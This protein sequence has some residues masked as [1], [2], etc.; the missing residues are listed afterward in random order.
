MGGAQTTD[1]HAETLDNAVI[2]S[3]NP[4]GTADRIDP[5]M[6]PWS[7]NR[8]SILGGGMIFASK[9]RTV[10]SSVNIRIGLDDPIK[11][12]PSW[13]IELGG[14][15]PHDVSGDW[16]SLQQVI[17]GNTFTVWLASIAEA[18]IAAHWEVPHGQQEIVVPDLGFGVS[19][20][21]IHDKIHIE[22]PLNFVIFQTIE[23]SKT[24]FSPLFQ[25]G[26]HFFPEHRISLSFDAAYVSY[27]NVPSYGASFDL[28][29]TGWLLRPMLQIRI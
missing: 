6:W 5:R 29:L 17:N 9:H 22:S 13:A 26:L 4:N 15:F 12:R 20:L 10:G 1:T 8:L 27:A 18:H 24:S 19:A 11:E 7:R 25:C 3:Q 2:Y 21:H 14:S 28:G 16:R 23:E